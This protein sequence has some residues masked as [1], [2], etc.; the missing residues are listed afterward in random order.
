MQKVH[1]HTGY[2]IVLESRG[3]AVVPLA[4]VDVRQFAG[5]SG[6]CKKTAA[7]RLCKD[8]TGKRTQSAFFSLAASGA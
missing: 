2:P 6:C 7:Q 1:K 8:M 3:R 5:R 4:C